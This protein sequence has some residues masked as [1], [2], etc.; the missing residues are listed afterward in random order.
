ML[1][2]D[3]LIQALQSLPTVVL[4]GTTYRI[5][6]NKYAGSPLSSIG[7]FRGGRY[8]PPDQF[9][10]LYIADAPSNALL[11]IGAMIRTA[12]GLSGVGCNPLLILS[13]DYQLNRVLSLFEDAHQSAIGT[14]L[15]ELTRSW[16]D[17]N[18]DGQMAATQKVGWAAYKMNGIEAL[19]VPS[20]KIDGAYNLVIFPNKLT[21]NSFVQVYD[22]DG[23]ITARVPPIELS[24]KP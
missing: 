9:E 4:Q 19:K 14:N 5:I 15:Q 24:L 7:S 22:K 17:V 11:E 23:L 18:A 10:A 8:N 12:K 3:A 2:D 1:N 16:R 21:G 6:K 20:A 13:L